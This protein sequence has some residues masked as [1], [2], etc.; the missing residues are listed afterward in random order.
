[1]KLPDH[2]EPSVIVSALVCFV[3]TVLLMVWSA[4]Y[5]S[6]LVFYLILIDLIETGCFS[7]V[8]SFPKGDHYSARPE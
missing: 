7:T 1:M 5:Q 6:P 2:I 4:V 8:L 3:T